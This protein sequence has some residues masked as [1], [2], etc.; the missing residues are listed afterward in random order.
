MLM[1]ALG[2]EVPSRATSKCF[3]APSVHPVRSA[4]LTPLHC[5]CGVQVPKV[6]VDKLFDEWDK[7]GGGSL[8]FKELQKV[9]TQAR[10]EPPTPNPALAAMKAVGKLKGLGKKKE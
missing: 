7:D 8:N 2:L 1:T 10:T 3:T 5:A 6:E 9:L 4:P